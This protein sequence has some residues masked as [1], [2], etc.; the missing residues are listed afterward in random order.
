MIS[1]GDHGRDAIP[2]T[3]SCVLPLR[4][5][6]ELPPAHY[7]P[8]ALTKCLWEGE[9]MEDSNSASTYLANLRHR[10]YTKQ[11]YSLLE[12]TPRGV[13]HKNQMPLQNGA[14]TDADTGILVEKKAYP[15]SVLHIGK[16]GL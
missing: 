13:M 12:A 8:E 4:K 14:D 5:G 1:K 6:S 2:G 16:T 11:L 3:W 7:S 15:V 9:G 10:L